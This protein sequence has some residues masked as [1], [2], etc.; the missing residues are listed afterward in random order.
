MRPRTKAEQQFLALGEDAV[1][2]LRAAAAA[3]TPRLPAHLAAIAALRDA[4]GHDA[5]AAALRRAVQ[6]RRFTAEDVR[7][8]LAAGPAAPTADPAPAPL[9]DVDLPAV[10]TRGLDAYRTETLRE[11]A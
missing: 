10:P 8:I 7:S 4:H 5:L 2:F 6:F 11:V 1:A 9:L 3:G